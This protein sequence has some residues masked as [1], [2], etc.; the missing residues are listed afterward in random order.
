VFQSLPGTFVSAN[1]VATNALVQPSL[2]RPLA[3]GAANVTV[4][5]VAPETMYTD[6]RNQLDIRL[7]KIVKYKST[8]T[9]FNVDFFNVNNASAVLA[10]NAAYAWWLRPTSIL[11]AR[12][13][14]LGAQFDF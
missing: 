2:G 10:V 1:F 11:T 9:T 6:R 7:G 8:K 3:G 4:N 5:I 14:R 12:F 13:M